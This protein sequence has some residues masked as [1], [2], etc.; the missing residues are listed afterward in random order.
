MT[1]LLSRMNQTLDPSFLEAGHVAYLRSLPAAVEALKMHGMADVV[2][3][4]VVALLSEGHVLLE[5]NP[6]LG[7]T[8]LVRALSAALGLGNEA[9]GRVQFTP[10]LMPS[11][12]TGTL[13]PADDGS[14]RLVFTRGPVFCSLLL[15]DEINR[16]TPKTQSAMLEAMAEYQVT[17][18]GE[19]HQLRHWRDAGRET[20]RTP[21]MVMATQ[22]P[23]DQEGT[24][25]LPEAQSDRFMFKIN[26]TT[27]GADVLDKIILK[28]LE[29]TGEPKQRQV[30]GDDPVQV[31]AAGARLHEISQAVMSVR[32]SPLVRDHINNLVQA[33]NL[34][35]DQLRGFD[36][37]RA[38]RLRELVEK[39]VTYPLGPRAGIALAR[40]S[41]GW[42]A[43]VLVD[44]GQAAHGTSAQTPR[45]LAEI[46]VPT[47]RHRIKISHDYASLATAHAEAAALD[48]FIRDLAVACAPQGPSGGNY[49]EDFR[50]A[51]ER[52]RMTIRL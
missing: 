22:N 41:V 3:A 8:A 42:A 49:P 6:G 39:R 4:L 13:M 10:D 21:F 31:M 52:A 16:A 18:L 24:Y 36:G 15:A 26:L 23:I 37:P 51:L 44:P 34:H 19:T 12:I 32:L 43:A 14:G 45:A 33:T 17:V 27:P 50:L 46:I 7:K 38:A 48:A 29:P 5:G 28:A 2:N 11:D 9:V 25:T 20:Y 30:V 35:F 1:G 47:L 40:A